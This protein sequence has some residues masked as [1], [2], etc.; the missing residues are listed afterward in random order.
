M[1][2]LILFFFYRKIYH[3][4]LCYNLKIF[5]VLATAMVRRPSWTSR[6]SST[7][8]SEENMLRS[9]NKGLT[10]NNDE[11][12]NNK[13]CCVSRPVIFCPSPSH[14]S[15]LV[16]IKPKRSCL[17]MGIDCN[18]CWL[19]SATFLVILLTPI[20][21]YYIKVLVVL[22]LHIIDIK[23]NMFALILTILYLFFYKSTNQRSKT[24]SFFKFSSYSTIKG[25]SKMSL[26]WNIVFACIV[27]QIGWTSDFVWAIS[28]CFST[29][30]QRKALKLMCGRASSC[31]S[32]RGVDS[33]KRG[34]SPPPKPN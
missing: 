1:L 21:N 22:S 27:S 17:N 15:Q 28:S 26:F 13:G 16:C 23:Y 4:E 6:P 31:W 2:Y 29:S 20:L 10:L 24:I 30:Q 34:V 14:L 7:K 32:S 9:D 3:L 18:P 5:C 8:T 25:W 11:S 33:I 19:Y 12:S